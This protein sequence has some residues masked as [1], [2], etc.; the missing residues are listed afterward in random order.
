MGQVCSGAGAS[1]HVSVP[2]DP[3]DKEL[4]P[5]DMRKTKIPNFDSFFDSASAPLNELVEIHNSIAESEEN[6]KAAAAALQGETQ[7]RLTVSGSGRVALVLWRFDDKDQVRILSAAEREIKLKSSTE[8]QEAFNV[9][10]HVITNLNSALERPSAGELICEYAEKRGRLFVTKRGQFD[11]LVR[12]VN[13]AVFTL[14]KHLMLQAH[15]T[16]L[17]EAMMVLRKEL[18]KVEDVRA[19]SVATDENGVIKIMNG[20]REM[21]LR[22]ID[23]LRAPVAQLR[24]ALVELIDNVDTAVTSVPELAESSAA[25][26]DEA[27]GFPA[28]IPDAVSNSGLSLTEMPKAATATTSNVK[29]LSNGPKIARATAI[30]IQYAVE[31]NDVTPC[32][33]PGK[34]ALFTFHPHGVLT[35]GF[36]FNGAHHLTFQ[37]AAC[38]WISAEN[39]F[40]FP[41]MRDI[42]HWMEFSSSTKASM[43]SIMRTGQNLCLLPGGFE[44]ATL[45]Q[46]G[47]HRVYIKNRFGF[48]KLALQHGYDIYPAYTFG[49]EYTYHAFPYLQQLRLQ[50]NRFRVPGAIFFGIPLCFFLPRP[51]VDLITVVSKP[52]RLPQIEH[53]SR[54]VVKEFH[55]KYMEALQDLFDSYKGVY[56]VDPK[57]TLE[58]Y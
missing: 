38:R 22:K 48:I 11:V 14:R 39:L 20:D 56:A 51:D 43:Q 21:D 58:F 6:L 32:V 1:K 50:L 9:S 27:K 25:F 28:K 42:L 5:I 17:S 15:M 55:D 47:K 16:S 18:S 34:R 8:L 3:A 24:D 46:R 33:E 23:N 12:D 2:R 26:V 44:E 13:V 57:A 7:V 4:D 29:A 36:S 52:L 37:R 30:M 54:E 10:D 35:C 19:L 41:L 45:F 40:W 31:E 53:P 49:E